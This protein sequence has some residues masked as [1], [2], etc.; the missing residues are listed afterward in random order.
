MVGSNI[1][2][3]SE[4]NYEKFSRSMLSIGYSIVNSY[5][6]HSLNEAYIII[7]TCLRVRI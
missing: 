7:R 4:D 3:I 5:S 2:S 1:T 6:H